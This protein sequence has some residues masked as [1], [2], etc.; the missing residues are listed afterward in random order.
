MYFRLG[1]VTLFLRNT[2][3]LQSFFFFLQGLQIFF[4]AIL[5]FFLQ[6]ICNLGTLVNMD[7]LYFFAH[8]RVILQPVRA[9]L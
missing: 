1:S 4:I 6:Q 9:C 3:M 8:S 2:G 5:Q 7:D